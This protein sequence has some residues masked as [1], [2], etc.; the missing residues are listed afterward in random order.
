MAHDPNCPFCQKLADPNGWPEDDVVWRFPHSDAPS[1][2]D[3][4]CAACGLGYKVTA[5]GVT[6]LDRG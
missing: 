4:R 5:S 2:A 6:E 3:A 1:D